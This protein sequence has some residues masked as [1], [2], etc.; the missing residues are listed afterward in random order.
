MTHD[1]EFMVNIVGLKRFVFGKHDLMTSAFLKYSA[2]EPWALHPSTRV[3]HPVSGQTIRTSTFREPRGSQ[4]MED[5]W[6][7]NLSVTY[8][9]PIAGSVQGSIGGEVANAT[10]EQ[11][12]VRINERTGRPHSSVASHQYPR[13]YR[14][15]VGFRF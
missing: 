10:N 3:A 14:L 15:K 2:G 8:Q 5:F 13:E 1:R 9:F 7:L 4:Q 11:A 6:N 12:V